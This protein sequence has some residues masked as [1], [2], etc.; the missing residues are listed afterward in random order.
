V[1]LRRIGLA[2]GLAVAVG[3]A[4]AAPPRAASI[5]APSAARS[6]PTYAGRWTLLPAASVFG[7]ARKPPRART[8]VLTLDGPWVTVHSVTQRDG[9]D[10][11][12]MDFRYRTDGEAVNKV[13]GQD[14]R[15]V[16]RREGSSLCFE[17]Q[18]RVLMLEV[19]VAERWSLSGDSLVMSRDTDSPMGKEHQRLVFGRAR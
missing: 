11:L 15:T 18:A 6:T 2:V 9:G 17:T 16:G 4:H 12:V 7:G 5:P 14:L 3:L 1:N 19:K 8:D 13:M 10:S